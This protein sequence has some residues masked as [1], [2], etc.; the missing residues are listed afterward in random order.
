MDARMAAITQRL[1][2]ANV[3]LCP[4]ILP[5]SGMIVQDE[6]Q[7]APAFRDAARAELGLSDLPTVTV[8]VPGSAAARAGVAPGDRIVAIDD[9]PMARS[10]GGDASYAVAEAVLAALDAAMASAPADLTVERAGKMLRIGLRGDMA[11]PAKVELVPGKRLAAS[12]DGKTVHVSTALAGFAGS[13]DAVAIIV[14]HEMAHNILRHADTLDAQGV[15]RGLLAP[16]GK[17]RSAIRATEIEADRFAVFMLARAGY[18]LD[19]AL[20]FLKRFGAK[21]DLGPLNDGT[22]P[23]KKERVA[24]AV[25]A[26]AEVRAL[27]ASGRDLVPAALP[28]VE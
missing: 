7:Y 4:K 19:V 6:G 28:L 27:K 23:G 13:D 21:T 22:H 24:R 12:A 3:A 15:K 8:V 10:A 18:D 2:L 17:N 11:C 25:Q 16:F 14:A 20:D 1:A 9:R 26:I 5:L